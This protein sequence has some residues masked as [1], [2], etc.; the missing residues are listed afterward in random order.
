MSDEY[1]DDEE[2]LLQ[3]REKVATQI[4]QTRQSL[5]MLSTQLIKID[6]Q[7]E[8]IAYKRENKNKEQSEDGA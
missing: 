1:S 5:N 6:A 2:K 8:F 3:N 4:D 7:L